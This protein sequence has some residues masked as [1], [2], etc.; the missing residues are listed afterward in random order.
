MKETIGFV[1]LGGMGSAMAANLLR[2]GYPLRVWNRTPERAAPLIAE[3]ARPAATPADAAATGGIVLT[4]VSDDQALEGVTRGPQ[5]VLAGLGRGGVHLSMSTVSPALARRL[6]EEH[7]RHGAAYLAAPVFGKPEV[8]AARKLWILVAGD[9][10]ARERARPV[11]EALG[12]AVYDFGDDAG[13][14]NVVKLC[15]NFLIGAAVE[16]MAE[17]FTLAQKHGVPRQQVQDFFSR[18][19][20]D[21]FVYRGYGELVA[22][23]KYEPVGAKPSLIRKDYGLVLEAANETLT[24]MPLA[25]LIHERLTSTVAKGR[26]DRDWSGFAREV[27]EAAG[28]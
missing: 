27:S 14:A 10:Q 16:A 15:G 18:T 5:G 3:G 9:K 25:Q 11:L 4:M 17:A 24:P 28:L 7:R 6:A 19:L 23:E 21:C 13:S 8:A 1:G 22:L 2:A 26:D 12:Q 20:F